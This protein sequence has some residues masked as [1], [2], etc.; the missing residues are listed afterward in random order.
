MSTEDSKPKLLDQLKLL[1]RTR[2]YSPRTIEAYEQWVRRYILY[3]KKRH[4]REMGVEEVED[5]LTYLVTSLNV[6]PAT[7]NQALSALIFL[8]RHFLELPLPPGIRPVRSRKTPKQPAIL[9]M[10]EVTQLLDRLEGPIKLACELLYGAGLRVGECVRLRIKDLDFEYKTIT[11]HN[12]KGAKDRV[13]PL[14]TSLNERLK[15]HIARVRELHNRDLNHGFGSVT[16]PYAL[17]RKLRNAHREFAWQFLFPSHTLSVD[18]EDGMVRRGCLSPSTL[19]RRLKYAARAV[20]IE[21]RVTCHTLRHSFATHLLQN[22]YDIR[23]VQELMGHNDVK[24]TMIYTHVLKRG[25]LGVQS[26]LD[27]LR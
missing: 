23:T 17:N 9:T 18:E 25:G 13:V 16:L 24:T 15:A 19:Q 14:P 26:P 4:P 21:K 10:P 6:A 11:I 27:R 8:Y 1:M 5:F 3:H 12:G 2:R 7:Q 20:G 22:G